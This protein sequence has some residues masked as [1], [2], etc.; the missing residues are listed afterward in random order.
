MK[1]LS[2]RTII[3]FSAFLVTLIACSSILK[4]DKSEER[5]AHK[6]YDEKLV[7][8]PLE[9]KPAEVPAEKEA[10]AE[11]KG[12]KA[13]KQS[14]QQAKKTK[15]DEGKKTS[16]S[17]SSTARQPELEDSEGFTGR[18][19]NVDPFK[20][21]E[22]L[23]FNISYFKVVAGTL[24]LE[25][26]PFASVNGAKAYHFQIRVKSNDFFSKFYAVDDVADTYVDYET[27]R[28]YNHTIDVRESK[29]LAS[30]RSLYDWETGKGSYWHKKI[31][32]EKGEEKKEYHWDLAP[33]AQNVVS[34]IFYLR[35]FNVNKV[36]KK[37]AFNVADE[38][39]NVIFRGEVLRKEDL[40]T[41]AGELK[42]V[43]IRPQIEVDGFFKPMGEILIWLTDDDRKML[44]RIESKIRIGTLVAKIT[45]IEKGQ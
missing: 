35:N 2:F 39:K 38:E 9:E 14:K 30:I 6:E 27:L 3:L 45:K 26:M 13:G 36:G 20:V 17:A 29:Q 22:K 34:A 10:K 4:I 16:M 33:Y 25:V 15:K 5:L 28:P 37:L 41:D 23:T 19:P 1:R 43:V 21:G 32:K 42:T 11:V 31:T 8:K 24:E 18:R 7:I 44:A 40:D 12:K